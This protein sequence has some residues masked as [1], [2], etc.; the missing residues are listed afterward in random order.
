MQNGRRPLIRYDCLNYV[1]NY[2]LEDDPKNDRVSPTP[3]TNWLSRPSYQLAA[4]GR[5]RSQVKLKIED[6]LEAGL[7]R[8]Y[9]PELYRQKCAA[10]FEHL[11]ESYPEHDVGVYA[12]AG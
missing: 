9:S 10:L 8:A 7:P 12:A 11:Y 5:A 2:V 6:V 3:K 4:E 1:L